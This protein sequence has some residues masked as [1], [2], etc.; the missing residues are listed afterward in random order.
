MR[1]RGGGHTVARSR[2]LVARLVGAG[3]PGRWRGGREMDGRERPIA[4][5]VLIGAT[6]LVLLAGCSRGGARAAPVATAAVA[7][8]ATPAARA[9]AVGTVTKT[10]STGARTVALSATNGAQLT[11]S[12][13]AS[14][15]TGKPYRDPQGRFTLT[16]PD[17]W[18]EAPTRTAA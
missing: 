18:A 12:P 16:L 6:A 5:G 3:A 1:C 7:S 4:R 15:G 13:A 10:P 17:G 2:V 8:P 14:P 9:T 11:T